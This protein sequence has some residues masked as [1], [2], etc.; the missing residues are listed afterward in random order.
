V[1]GAGDIVAP[2]VSLMVRIQVQNILPGG[3]GDS[4]RDPDYIQ[5][6]TENQTSKEQYTSQRRAKVWGEKTEHKYF[7]DHMN[8][9]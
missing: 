4:G 1:D 2:A 9:L 3:P 7:Q 5:Q 6:A 8:K